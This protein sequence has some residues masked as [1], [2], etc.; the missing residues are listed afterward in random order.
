MQSVT[1]AAAAA[2]ARLQDLKEL[3]SKRKVSRNRIFL[4][5]HLVIHS[6]SLL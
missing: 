5:N 6:F 2:A 3:S 4:E 1:T